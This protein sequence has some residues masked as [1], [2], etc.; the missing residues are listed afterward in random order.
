MRLPARSG[1]A[2]LDLQAGSSWRKTGGDADVVKLITRK[3]TLKPS[4]VE[5]RLRLAERERHRHAGGS[6]QGGNGSGGNNSGSG[7]AIGA[8]AGAAGAAGAGSGGGKGGMGGSA[9]YEVR[10]GCAGY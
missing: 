2:L 5:G 8:A 3:S 6:A 7:N 1:V 4:Y 10:R 9:S